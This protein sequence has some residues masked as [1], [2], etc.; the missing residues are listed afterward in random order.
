MVQ[1]KQT[2]GAGYRTEV[3]SKYLPIDPNYVAG[4][5][6]SRDSTNGGAGWHNPQLTTGSGTMNLIQLISRNRMGTMVL[7]DWKY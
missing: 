1:V 3:D 4:A 7:R 5:V 6:I 2:L